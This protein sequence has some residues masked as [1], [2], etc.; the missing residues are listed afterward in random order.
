MQVLYFLEILPQC[1]FISRPSLVWLDFEG[2]VYRDRHAQV[3]SVDLFIYYI[4]L[5]YI[6]TYIPVFY[7]NDLQI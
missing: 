3:N 4:Y 5:P 1:G 6:I 2:S 7:F